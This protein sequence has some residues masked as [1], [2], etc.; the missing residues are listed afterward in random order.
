MLHVINVDIFRPSEVTRNIRDRPAF[1][2]LSAND[3][4]PAEDREGEA[5]AEPKRPQGRR[6]PAAP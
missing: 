1:E 4:W 5:P 3:L 6:A 2:V